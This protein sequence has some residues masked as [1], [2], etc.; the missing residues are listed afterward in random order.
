ML[1]IDAVEH[2]PNDTEEIMSVMEEKELRVR[3]PVEEVELLMQD[4]VTK[5]TDEN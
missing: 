5:A 4:R 3:A 2:F 1:Y